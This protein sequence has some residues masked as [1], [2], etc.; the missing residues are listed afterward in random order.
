MTRAHESSDCHG[1]ATWDRGNGFRR[2]NNAA[3]ASHSIS[4][5]PASVRFNGLTSDI[6]REWRTEEQCHV[7]DLLGQ[8]ESAQGNGFEH[9]RTHRFRNG[10]SHGCFN[11]SWSNGIHADLAPRTLAAEDAHHG[12]DAR[13]GR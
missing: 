2:G 12:D 1:G 7:R 9:F 13:F 3:K 11:Y 10:R 6:R 4:A 5:T 8:A